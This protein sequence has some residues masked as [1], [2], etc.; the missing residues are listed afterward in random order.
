MTAREV[1]DLN[2]FSEQILQYA[3]LII[4]HQLRRETFLSQQ[5]NNMPLRRGYV[6]MFVDETFEHKTDILLQN[7]ENV[8]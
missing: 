2:D 3:S 4:L 7:H 6:I 8:S 1:C 5:D